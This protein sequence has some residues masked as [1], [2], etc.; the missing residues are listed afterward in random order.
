MWYSFILRNLGIKNN[1]I[2]TNKITDINNN[3]IKLEYIKYHTNE[4]KLEE[5]IKEVAKFGFNVVKV[6][7]SK[8]FRAAF[9]VKKNNI[10]YF[11]KIMSSN[12]FED[13]ER[14]IYELL[15]DK[16]LNYL[17]KYHNRYETS[18]YFI[19]VYEYLEGKSL[20]AYLNDNNLSQKDILEIIRGILLGLDELH[21][22]SIIHGDIK[23]QN[24]FV[25][26]DFKIKIIDYD[27]S[28]INSSSENLIQSKNIF[29]TQQYI[30]PESYHLSIY[31]KESDIWSTGII[32]FFLVTNEFPF[33][34]IPDFFDVSS[35]YRRNIFKQPNFTLL[36][37]KCIERKFDKRISILV[38]NL[39]EFK[40]E[41][42]LTIE[43][44]IEKIDEILS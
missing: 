31:A 9:I 28:K 13:Q 44:S 26:D 20:S 10:F 41:N 24:V 29:G 11:L 14:S 7:Y 30:S 19:Y 5:M 32:L 18:K 21:N 12:Y 17:L 40:M 43:K 4:S 2:K 38:R 42:R 27:L 36:E 23:L 16:K 15:K 3:N 33:D 8:K 34:D 37:N 6:K 25:T 39:L 35:I 1:N 22:Y